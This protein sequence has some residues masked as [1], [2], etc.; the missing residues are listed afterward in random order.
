MRTQQAIRIR[1][2]LVMGILAAIGIASSSYLLLKQRAPVPFTD[3]FTVKA[4]FAEAD[5]VISGIG[6]PVN[7]VGV[8]VGQVTGVEQRGGRALVTMALTNDDMPRLRRDASAALEPITPLKDMQIVLDP[9]RASTPLAESAVIPVARTSVPADLGDLFRILDTD[10]R[11]YLTSMLAAFDRGTRNR[12]G[13]LRAALR[14]LGPT[15]YQLR[16]LTRSTATR[17]KQLARLVTNLGSVSRAAAAP[18]RLGD[19]VVAGNATLQALADEGRSLSRA[20]GEFPPTLAATRSTLARL[21]PFAQELSPTLSRLEPGL[22]KLPAALDAMV[23]FFGRATPTLRDYVRPL[24]RDS[25]PL[26][27]TAAPAVR[28]LKSAA[29]RITGVA[30]TLNYFLNE[31][32]YNPPG[33]DEGFLFWLAWAGH[34]VASVFGPA[35]AHGGIVRATTVVDCGPVEAAPPDLKNM[36]ASLGYCPDNGGSGGNR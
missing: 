27:R 22:R 25:R 16:R 5:G 11:T 28:K 1:F 30:Q 9:G 32:A 14:N 23:P 34:N 3:S 20:L 4:E 15:A 36:L 21:Q 12:A 24:V 26:V 31:L 13:D 18:H 10:T 17:R 29:P 6:Q 19:A 7:V 8:K 2:L 33:D 35:D